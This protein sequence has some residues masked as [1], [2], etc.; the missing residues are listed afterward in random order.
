M[1]EG[2]AGEERGVGIILSEKERRDEYTGELIGRKF[3]GAEGADV[4]E[5]GGD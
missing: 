1:D 3:S 4:E 5:R 2:G